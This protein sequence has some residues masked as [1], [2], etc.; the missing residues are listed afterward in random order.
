MTLFVYSSSALAEML[1][2]LYK[3]LS[4]CNIFMYRITLVQGVKSGL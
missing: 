4:A 2:L 1:R 3:M